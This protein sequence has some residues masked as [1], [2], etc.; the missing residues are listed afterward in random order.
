[1]LNNKIFLTTFEEA[2]NSYVM[3]KVVLAMIIGILIE[4]N[5]QLGIIF[6]IIGMFSGA[7][8]MAFLYMKRKKRLPHRYNFLNGL[9]YIMIWVCYGMFV[10]DYQKVDAPKLSDFGDGVKIGVLIEPTEEKPKTFRSKIKILDS[11]AAYGKEIL[12][13]FEKDSTTPPPQFGDLVGFYSEVR[14]IES[15]GNPLEFDYQQ[16]MSKQGVY[17]QTYIKKQEYEILKTGYQKGIKYYGAKIRNTLIDIYRQ[18]GISG[19]Q[20]A[21][22]EALTLGYKADLDPETVLTFQTSGAMHILAVSGLH[23]GIIM[24][25]TS[26]LLSFI[27]RKQKKALVAK[28]VIIILTLWIFA[29]ITGF[30]PSVCRSAVM[31]SMI[32][33]AERINSNASTYNTLAVSAFILL[34]IN[35]LLLYNVGFGLSYLAVLAII[36]ITPFV[37]FTIPK[38]DPVHDTKWIHVKKWFT[39]YFLGIIYVSI[40]AQIGTSILSI[41]TF[42]MFP[43]YFLI[44]NIFVIPLSYFIMITAIVLLTVS[45]CPPLMFVV[46]GILKLLLNLLTGTVSWIE[47]L[48]GSSIDDL[49]ITSTSA[50]LLCFGLAYLVVFGKYKRALQLKI[51]LILLCLFAA[52]ITIFNSAKYPN[53]QV[54]VY[55]KRNTQLYSIKNGDKMSIITDNAELDEK[56][57]SPA[58]INAALAHANLVEIL[59]TDSL[60]SINERFWQIDNKNFYIV[61]STEQIEI[62]DEETLPVDYIIVSENTF[63]NAEVLIENFKCSNVIFDSSNSKK[64]VAARKEEYEKQGIN[65]FDVSRQ[66]AFI[67]GDGE[68]TIWWY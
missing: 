12:A 31:F 68:K 22:L 13:Y 41:K 58:T 10:T 11:T 40:A 46:T 62:M 16:Y 15:N 19:Q 47:S 18:S 25:I 2:V 37:K 33:I 60:S 28:C 1:M 35:P 39:R 30:S 54:I 66:G 56:S 55:N 29:A 42:N 4:R 59:K 26:A 53:S 52:S 63:I 50:I 23:T 65:C 7:A 49:F 6:S 38:Y 44:T 5:A 14:Y 9:S 45:W 20:L 48:P 64:F 57:L 61:T 24:M 34:S 8:L 17:C 27:K 51:A 21:V 36:S 67:Y 32:V 3:V 43:T